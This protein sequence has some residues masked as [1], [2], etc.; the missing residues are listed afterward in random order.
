LP[1]LSSEDPTYNVISEDAECSARQIIRH[2]CAGLKHYFEAH[3]HIKAQQIR[4]AK[5][6]DSG[7]LMTSSMVQNFYTV[8]G[9]KVRY[10][11]NY[12]VN[13][14]IFILYLFFSPLKNLKLRF[15]KR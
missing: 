8:P 7:L 4:R 13:N 12:K 9:Y 1:L 11:K 6:R 2:V 3:L 10:F 14:L 15:M 5:M